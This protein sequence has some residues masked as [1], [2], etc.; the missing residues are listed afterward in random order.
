MRMQQLIFGAIS[1]LVLATAI[2]IPFSNY[3]LD[4]I[5]AR[6]TKTSVELS[7]LK[8]KNEALNSLREQFQRLD[9]EVAALRKKDIELRQ[10]LPSEDAVVEN[11]KLLQTT[12]SSKRLTLVSTNG[13]HDP[14]RPGVFMSPLKL[15]VSGKTADH[16]EYLRYLADY[17]KLLIVR[18]LEVQGDSSGQ[19]VLN[20]DLDLGVYIPSKQ[21]LDNPLFR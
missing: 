13:R 8:K 15:S 2:W 21:E 10:L 4:P 17:P 3:V 6:N 9:T 20:L 11:F 19:S 1:F 16:S 14:Y 7:A 18:R 5:D 12:A